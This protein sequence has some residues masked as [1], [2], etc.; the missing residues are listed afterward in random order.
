MTIR[1]LYVHQYFNTRHM[2]GGTR[3]YELAHR[4]VGSGYE[5]TMLTADR[6]KTF[7]LARHENIDGIHV[8]WIPGA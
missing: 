5:V 2:S 3:S 4:L 1:V 7:G 8:I 6:T